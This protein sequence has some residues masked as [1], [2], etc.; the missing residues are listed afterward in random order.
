[1]QITQL[2][3]P[4]GMIDFGIGQPALS[5][6]P[7][8]ILGQAAEHRLK[9]GDPSILQ[10]G[11]EPGNG[12]FR[13]ALSEFLSEGYRMPVSA[14]HLFITSGATQ[15]LNLICTYFARSGDTIFVE[16]PS[17]FLALHLF[18]DHHLNVVS[19]PVDKDGL[20]IEALVE[21]LDRHKPVFLYTVPTFHNP[22]TV[23]LSAD[24]R[25]RLVRLGEKHNFYIIADEV[26]QLLAYTVTPPPPMMTYDN[27]GTVL[28]L[29]S[30]SK[31]LAP[32]LRLGW[33]Q[34]KPTLFNK[35]KQSGL[36][37]S[38]GGLN[39][40]TSGIVQSV[41]ELGL[42][43][44]HLERLRRV[45][46]ER[47]ANLSAALRKHLPVGADF[48]E[49]QGGFFIWMRLPEELDAK[50]FCSKA[51]K[52]NLDFQPGIHFSNRQG[53]RNYLRLSFS[54]YGVKDLCEG[55]KRLVNIFSPD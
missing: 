44:D 5:L 23:T 47:S 29:G 13:L 8:E 16:E 36:L 10:Y 53:L 42:Q 28:S 22:S 37:L 11:T 14:D 30:F 27:S 51:R 38:G 48:S 7:V 3:L 50:S 21:K 52:Q 17:Y 45:Y 43:H 20:I 46:G 40:F 39:P 26:Y 55:I 18:K 31:I 32:G 6:L 2:D 12:Y 24:R 4:E 19:L 54:Y 1:M 33:I 35:L 49:P 34:A 9:Q 15:G 41:L 25:D